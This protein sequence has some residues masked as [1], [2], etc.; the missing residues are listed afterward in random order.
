MQREPTHDPEAA[1]AR[2]RREF[3]SLVDRI[4]AVQRDLSNRDFIERAP[5]EVVARRRAVCDELVEA[6]TAV[7]ERMERLEEARE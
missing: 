4:R 5:A 1:A 6:L 3:E 7:R 2:L